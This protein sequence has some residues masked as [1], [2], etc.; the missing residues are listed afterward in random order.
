MV[1]NCLEIAIAFDPQR[2]RRHRTCYYFAS[3]SYRPP[4]YNPTPCYLQPA[5][6]LPRPDTQPNPMLFS[7]AYSELSDPLRPAAEKFYSPGNLGRAM[8]AG[9]LLNLPRPTAHSKLILHLESWKETVF[10]RHVC[11]SS[12]PYIVM[13]N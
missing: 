1:S 13:E 5:S 10:H 9:C 8:G 3:C 7:S 6:S 4:T 12:V 2:A 11:C